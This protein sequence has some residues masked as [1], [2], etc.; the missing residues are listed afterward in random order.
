[1]HKPEFKI[2][3]AYNSI[4]VVNESS[5]MRLISTI[6]IVLHIRVHIDA[7]PSTGPLTDSSNS[8]S[9]K[10]SDRSVLINLAKTLSSSLQKVMTANNQKIENILGDQ[11]E[12]MAAVETIENDVNE[13]KKTSKNYDENYEK[14]ETEVNSLTN[15]R[16]LDELL[17]KFNTQVC[18]ASIEVLRQDM[19]TRIAELKS[20]E[21]VRENEKQESLSKSLFLGESFD[22]DDIFKEFENALAEYELQDEELEDTKSEKL[23]NTEV[24]DPVG[25]LVAETNKFLIDLD[26]KYSNLSDQITSLQNIT[27]EPQ[28]TVD[29]ELE[30]KINTKM[31]KLEAKYD[32][33]LKNLQSIM[34]GEDDDIR[35]DI[36]MRTED[37]NV[38]KKTTSS[39]LS[40]YEARIDMLEQLVLEFSQQS[41]EVPIL[42][43]SSTPS[44][45]EMFKSF[46]TEI[47]E[48]TYDE[49]GGNDFSML[50]ITNSEDLDNL[51]PLN[52]KQPI[53]N[54]KGLNCEK[55]SLPSYDL[56]GGFSYPGGLANEVPQMKD[57]FGRSKRQQQLSPGQNFQGQLSLP[58]PLQTPRT[59]ETKIQRPSNQNFLLEACDCE[60]LRVKTIELDHEMKFLS[61]EVGSALAGMRSSLTTLL[62]RIEGVEKESKNGRQVSCVATK[63]ALKM[64]GMD[65][66]CSENC[67]KGNCPSHL[68]S[69]PNTMN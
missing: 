9:R 49:L 54:C 61:A 21:I 1:M 50:G 13:M 63:E 59:S 65:A 66:W 32:F 8:V 26:S 3:N 19:D 22:S 34:Q 57:K 43:F 18:N 44:T 68:C 24:T 51:E 28:L 64:P 56:P 55:N 42:E 36:T 37:F 46:T 38:L 11:Q 17:W 16:E 10:S 62:H 58:P 48:P 69:C 2:I 53:P 30:N 45:T 29:P 14:L 33:L 5:K 20:K 31:V 23:T 52:Q 60:K 39:R 27:M 47:P 40:V 15:R 4:S 6:F 67:R 7:L 41:T 25:N 12:V 35:N